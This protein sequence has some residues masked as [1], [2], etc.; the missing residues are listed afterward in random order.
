MRGQTTV[1]ITTVIAWLLTAAAC[2][3]HQ[4]GPVLLSV[5]PDTAAPEREVA[6]TIHGR[7][8][9]RDVRVSYRDSS[10]SRLDD[11]FSVW[12]GDTKLVDVVYV[13]TE[14]LTAK[15][16]AMLTTAIYDLRLRDPA[17]RETSL[18]G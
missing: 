10:R 4:A 14:T 15:I 13:D 16:R 2:E 11:E 12:L 8:F 7:N 6:L 5:T 18:A 9:F 3:T 17:G 1:G